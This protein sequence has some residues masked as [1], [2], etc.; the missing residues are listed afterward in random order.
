ML[1]NDIVYICLVEMPLEVLHYWIYFLLS[2]PVEMKGFDP[3]RLIG[4]KLP[5]AAKILAI[6][7]GFTKVCIFMVHF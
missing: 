1:P 3:I 6:S 2:C 7:T 5:I 4:Q